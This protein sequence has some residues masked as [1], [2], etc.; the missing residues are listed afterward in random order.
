[1][2][3]SA[4]VK[5]SGNEIFETI[6]VRG[7]GEIMVSGLTITVSFLERPATQDLGTRQITAN[8]TAKLPAMIVFLDDFNITWEMKV[9]RAGEAEGVWE[10]VGES[11]NDWYLTFGMPIA[12]GEGTGYK[13][14]HTLFDISCRYGMGSTDS[15]LIDGVWKYFV[16]KQ[17]KRSDG[18]P[19]KYY[20][21]WTDGNLASKTSDLLLFKDGE[22]TGWARL[23]LDV[24]K[25]QGFV[26]GDNI[27][28]VKSTGPSGFLLKK[29]KEI[30][31][32]GSFPN[33]EYPFKNIIGTPQYT[34]LNTYNWEYA[35]VTLKSSL[36]SQNNKKPRLDFDRHKLAKVRG[37]LYDPSY[38]IVYGSPK[39]ISIP[40]VQY[41]GKFDK[42]LEI[43]SL[44]KLVSAYYIRFPGTLLKIKIN[45]QNN[46][47]N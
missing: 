24:L 25:V 1:L 5:F 44:D 43:D 27:V 37:V 42:F 26:E 34:L 22:C 11:V 7:K 15:S 40:S 23:F 8:L 6:T 21:N 35:E 16:D 31:G 39:N 30:S 33:T 36:E 10:P 19:L 4:Q 9:K 29:W 47:I 45:N 2:D 38:G 46:E 17:V 14:F 41:P 18:E 32:Q 20:G 3:V 12:E 28:T 13:H